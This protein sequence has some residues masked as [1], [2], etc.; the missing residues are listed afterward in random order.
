MILYIE[1][2]KDSTRKLLALIN[3]FGKVAGYKINAQKSLVFLY[4]NHEKSEREIKETL[5]VTIA[6]KRIKYLGIN[7]PKEAKDLYAENYKTLMKEIK[8]DTNSWRDI[9]CSWIGRINIVKMTILCKATYRFNA[10]PIKLPMA[11]FTEL[12]QKISQFVWKQKRSQIT[13]AILRKK[14][15]AGGIR[16]PDFRLYYKTT[17]IKMVWYW[18]KNRNIIQWNR[19]ESPEINPRNMVILFLIKEARI[20]NGEKTAS[21]ISGSGKTG[22]LHVDG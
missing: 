19:I 13:K 2:P 10:I 12:E 22:Q 6:K 3:E 17:V 5:P 16:L 15:E 9:P 21:S 20:Y 7:L 1:N 11:F 14:N 18:H 4:T 8:D